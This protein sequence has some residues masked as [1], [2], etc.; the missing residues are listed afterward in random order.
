[1]GFIPLVP[2]K[3]E[4]NILISTVSFAQC[5][6]FYEGSL[7]TFQFLNDKIHR[8]VLFDLTLQF[9]IGK[10]KKKHSPQKV[11]KLRKLNSLILTE[12]EETKT[13]YFAPKTDRRK[14]KPTPALIDGFFFTQSS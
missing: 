7:F 13:K 10:L 6:Y 1:M 12:R 5:V 3:L 4:K 14:R 9:I 11:Y 2:A 8:Y